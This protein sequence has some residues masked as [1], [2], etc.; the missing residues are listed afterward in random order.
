MDAKQHQGGEELKDVSRDA[1]GAVQTTGSGLGGGG[2]VS[3]D[4]GA[5]RSESGAGSAPYTPDPGSPGG[6]SGRSPGGV[7]PIQKDD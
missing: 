2:S 4:R 3:G 5:G 6:M 1:A 7:S